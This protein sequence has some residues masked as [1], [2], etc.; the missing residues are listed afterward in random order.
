MKLNLEGKLEIDVGGTSTEV[1]LNMDQTTKVTISD[2][3]PIAP[4]APVKK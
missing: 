1:Q 3:D 2:T 4:V